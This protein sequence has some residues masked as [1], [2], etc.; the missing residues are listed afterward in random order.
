MN[1]RTMN[2]THKVM[3]LLYDVMTL[4]IREIGALSVWPKYGSDVIGLCCNS[5]DLHN[6]YAL[7]LT[8]WL[9]LGSNI[10]HNSTQKI[11]A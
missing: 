5:A 1:F 11:L 9:S 10:G 6:L 2:T 4:S 3:S 8:Q 7:H